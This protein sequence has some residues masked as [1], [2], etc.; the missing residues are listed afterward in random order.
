MGLQQKHIQFFLTFGGQIF[1]LLK[2]TDK[3]QIKVH[4]FANMFK[5]YIFETQ[6][7]AVIRNRLHIGVKS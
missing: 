3:G 7:F 2:Q 5:H 1:F 4:P 6:R